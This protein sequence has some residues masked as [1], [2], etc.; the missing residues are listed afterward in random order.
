[1]VKLFWHNSMTLQSGQAD[2]ELEQQIC[3]LLL[4]CVGDQFAISPPEASYAR[5]SA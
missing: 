4:M 5:P 2:T 3:D 1:M